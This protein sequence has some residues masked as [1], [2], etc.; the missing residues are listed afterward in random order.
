MVLTALSLALGNPQTVFAAT[1][2]EAALMELN[3]EDLMQVNVIS[4]AKQEQPWADSA[5]A[6]FVITNEDIRRS[7]VTSLAEAQRPAS[8]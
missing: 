1:A 4:A 5:A 2:T 7:G 3:I 6:V 8:R